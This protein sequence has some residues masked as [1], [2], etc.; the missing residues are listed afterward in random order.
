MRS[1]ETL[2]G[3]GKHLEGGEGQD[4][5]RGE[6]VTRL[7][8]FRVQGHPMEHVGC[9]TLGTLCI[10]VALPAVDSVLGLTV[11]LATGTLPGVLA[12]VRGVEVEGGVLT[13][14]VGRLSSHGN[15]SYLVR[16]VIISRSVHD[17]ST[18]R[19]PDRQNFLR[20]LFETRAHPR[21]RRARGVFSTSERS[22]QGR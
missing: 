8:L 19:I 16:V 6:H 17:V 22:P 11:T 13:V 2:H 10:R 14:V 15:L 20:F 9:V 12:L 18:V 1:V 21:D 5:C 3:R 4:R 7:H